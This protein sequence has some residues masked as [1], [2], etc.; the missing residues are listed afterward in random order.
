MF[1]TGMAITALAGLGILAIGVLYLAIPQAMAVNFGL[2]VVPDPD[3]TPWLRLKG[4]RDLA[5]GIVAFV[6]LLTAERHVLAGC[7]LAF[8]IVPLGDALTILGARGSRPVALLIHGS[9]A[10]L[11]LAGAG[12]LLL[13]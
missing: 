9:T 10:A 6:L 12:A 5:T 11:M 8:T 13:A 4:I 7:L 1:I 3:A 2:P